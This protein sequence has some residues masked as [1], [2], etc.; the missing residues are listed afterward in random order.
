MLAKRFLLTGDM[1]DAAD[2]LR[3]GLVSHVVAPTELDEAASAFAM[4]LAAGAPLAIRYTKLAVNAAMK[5]AFATAFDAA[6]AYETVTMASADHA[7]ALAAAVDKR[8]P[9]FEGR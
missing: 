1:V 8:I 4:R 3:L 7:E 2:A 9:R 6:L 5:Q